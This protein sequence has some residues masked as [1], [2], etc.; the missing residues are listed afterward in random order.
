MKR[1][2]HL[3]AGLVF[4]GA[5]IAA[6]VALFALTR[7]NARAEPNSV[8][9]YADEPTALNETEVT[10]PLDAAASVGSDTELA[11]PEEASDDSELS[12]GSMISVAA[13][14]GTWGPAANNP[15]GNPNA[16]CET[17]NTVTFNRDGTYRD[18]G[19]YGRYRIEGS[20]IVYYDRVLYDPGEDS[21]DRSDFDQ[22][23]VSRAQLMD[24]NTLKEDSSMLKRCTSG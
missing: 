6:G 14:V 15:L 7:P 11:S 2:N 4:I 13:I 3:V 17:D 1:S 21:E 12:A 22:P 20:T 9:P 19:S 18:G 23:L 24:P 8:D 5:C 10:E 16:P